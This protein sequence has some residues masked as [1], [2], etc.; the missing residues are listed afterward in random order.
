M[1]RTLTAYQPCERRR[2]RKTLQLYHRQR[3]PELDPVNYSRYARLLLGLEVRRHLE[4]DDAVVRQTDAEHECQTV[5]TTRPS[6]DVAVEKPLCVSSSQLI[7]NET[8]LK[9]SVI[10]ADGGDLAA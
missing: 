8:A 4:L 1:N 9:S 10:S 2:T 7:E 5:A 3:W 6:D